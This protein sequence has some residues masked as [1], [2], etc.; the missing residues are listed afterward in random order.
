MVMACLSLILFTVGTSGAVAE[1]AAEYVAEV[2]VRFSNPS[3]LPGDEVTIAGTVAAGETVLAVV[4]GTTIGSGIAGADGTFSFTV[5]IPDLPTGSFALTVTSGGVELGSVPIDVRG[6][7]G[8]TGLV[9]KSDE[10]EL[11]RD[12][13]AAPSDQP[14]PSVLAFNDDVPLAPFPWW[15]VVVGLMVV[16]GAAVL[17]LR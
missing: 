2:N 3:P 13:A 11:G 16:F 15:I 4:D 14:A 12:Q 8:A 10:V 1:A 5:T 17:I 9:S 6:G 7:A